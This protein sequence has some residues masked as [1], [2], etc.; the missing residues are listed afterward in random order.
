MSRQSAIRLLLAC[1]AAAGPAYIVIGLAQILARDGFDVRRHALS[2]LSNG[3]FGWI[4]V[5][6]FLLAGTFVIAGAVGIR[7]LLHPGRGGT[8]GPVLLC[9]YGIGL[10]G[11][12]VFIA[13][14]SAGFPPGA[15]ADPGGMSRSGLLHF[16]FGA[17]GFYALIAACFV[18]ARRFA[19]IGRPG[20]A[21][22]SAATGIFFLGSFVAIASGPPSEATMLVFYAA[23]ALVWLWHSALSITLLRE[24]PAANFSP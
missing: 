21:V 9:L 11:A 17:I 15:P 23:V 14:P 24:V 2:L 6:N 7:R 4:Q 1:S 3:D 12:G 19:G 22:Y 16:A 10:I 20:W 5:A 13:D 18:F 8:W